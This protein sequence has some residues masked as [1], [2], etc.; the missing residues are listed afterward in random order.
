MNE[1]VKAIESILDDDKAFMLKSIYAPEVVVTPMA[2]ARRDICVL[3]DGEIRSYGNLDGSQWENV[4]KDRGY[5]SSLDGGVSWT[6]H[7]SSSVME[8]CTYVPEWD[9]YMKFV[10]KDDGFYFLTSK[11]GP[12]DA[13][14]KEVR[15]GDKGFF[16]HF[17]PQKS[18]YTDRIWVTAQKTSP[19]GR[20]EPHYFYSDDK[21]QSWSVVKIKH[22]ADCPVVYPHKGPRWTHSCGTEPHAIE[23]DSG[24][25]MMI[26]RNSND[27]FY[28]T[29]SYDGGATWS[30]PEP[31]VFHGTDTTAYL[32]P[33]TDGRVMAFW[34]NTQPLPELNHDTQIPPLDND[35]KKGVWEDVFTNR[36]VA[37]A[38]IS[39]DGGKTWRGFREIHLNT[40]RN[41]PDFRY[42]GNFVP[43]SDKSVHQFQAYE[44][45]YGK[46]LVCMGQSAY[47]RKLVIFDIDWLCETDRS[48]DF[49]AG[50]GNLTTHVYLKS[51]SGSTLRYGNGHCAWNRI[52]G[53]VMMPDPEGIPLDRAYICKHNDPRRVSGVD[54]LVWNFGATHTGKI[55]VDVYIVEK[56]IQFTL[57]DRWFNAQDVAAP[58][59]SAF[60]FDLDNAD[61]G[62][63]FVTVDIEY[64]TVRGF[65][66]VSVGDRV[67]FDVRMTNPAPCGIS[68]L[69][70]Q[71][72]PDGES[73]GAYIKKLTKI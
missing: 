72:M 66:R 19:D 27:F 44:L 21:G 73:D 64:D 52:S 25:M 32:L 9:I 6:K 4:G 50:L 39:D 35:S 46:V 8:S 55:S 37:H 67:V 18:R 13:S 10:A 14:P 31:S 38:A 60:T 61:I 26:L 22:P 30:D 70:I 59:L 24:K 71:C 63:G 7:R 53:A 11:I 2:D 28:Q 56:T 62:K 54:G 43:C 20:N 68:Y 49:L 48:E 40:I 34:N 29:F 16:D 36:D 65:A 15:A 33:L 5:L 17:L 51:L 57:T 45:P 69:L 41:S 1:Y 58:S 23:I 42:A 3:K 12:D 47:C